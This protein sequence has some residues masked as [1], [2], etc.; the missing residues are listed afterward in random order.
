[1]RTT[2][3]GDGEN[4]SGL[5]A[6]PL[7]HAAIPIIRSVPF[8]NSVDVLAGSVFLAPARAVG[9]FVNAAFAVA[10]EDASDPPF[11]GGLHGGQDRRSAFLCPGV[12]RARAVTGILW[13]P[14][15]QVS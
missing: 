14:S 7:S 6:L 5:N 3:K 15:P 11:P 4:Y 13:R 8:C 9:E 12:H 1:M 10:L 2:E